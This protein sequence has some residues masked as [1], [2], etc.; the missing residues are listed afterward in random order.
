MILSRIIFRTFHS[1]ISIIRCKR[2]IF[3]NFFLQMDMKILNIVKRNSPWYNIF[4][5]KLFGLFFCVTILTYNIL[6]VIIQS[7]QLYMLISIELVALFRQLKEIFL[8]FLR[9]YCVLLHQPLPQLRWGSSLMYAVAVLHQALH[10]EPPVL[11]AVTPGTPAVQHRCSREP[12]SMHRAAVR[13]QQ[14]SLRDAC[15]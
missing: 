15:S 14:S 8:V 9:C 11:H 4:K 1:L 10:Q 2:I 5:R 3:K 13:G 7:H 12:R 6:W